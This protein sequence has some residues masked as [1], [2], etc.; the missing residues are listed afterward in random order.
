[1]L[2][3]GF[4]SRTYSL[5]P[6]TSHLALEAQKLTFRF[7]FTPERARVVANPKTREID[8]TLEV[9]LEEGGR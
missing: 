5:A 4:H 8:R 1:L 6:R 9:A 3:G 2:A 7:G